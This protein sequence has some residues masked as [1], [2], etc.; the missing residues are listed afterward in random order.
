M[1]SSGRYKIKY[2]FSSSGEKKMIAHE[3]NSVN[4]IIG[5]K[6]NTFMCEH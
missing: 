4:F 1:Q 3:E 6:N 5:K 2:I